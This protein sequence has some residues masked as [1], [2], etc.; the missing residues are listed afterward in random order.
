MLASLREVVAAGGREADEETVVKTLER[1]K[2]EGRDEALREDVA[3]RKAVDLLVENATAIPA[4]QAEAREALWTP[5]KEQKE[6]SGQIWTP[7]D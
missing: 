5:A 6:K 1:I 7:G 4:E 2:E 3:M